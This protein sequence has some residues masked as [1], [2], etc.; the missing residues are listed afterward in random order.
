[1]LDKEI[2]ASCVVAYG[3][4]LLSIGLLVASWFVPGGDVGRTAIIVCGAAATATI[5]TYFIALSRRVRAALIVATTESGEASRMR[6][7]R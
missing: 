1:M 2:S 5:R 7:V 3:L 4:W 6:T